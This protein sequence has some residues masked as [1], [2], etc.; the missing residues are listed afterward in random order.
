M[1][2]LWKKSD[3]CYSNGDDLQQIHRVSDVISKICAEKVQEQLESGEHQEIPS[4]MKSNDSNGNETKI[5]A[6]NVNKVNHED[7]LRED[8]GDAAVRF[9][10]EGY[11]EEMGGG[12]QAMHDVIAKKSTEFTHG[13]RSLS[14]SP[15]CEADEEEISGKRGLVKKVVKNLE[16]DDKIPLPLNAQHQILDNKSPS[17]KEKQVASTINVFVNN[18]HTV[19]TN[20]PEKLGLPE[21]LECSKEEG[22]ALH[23]IDKLGK[24][25]NA[26]DILIFTTR[27]ESMT[28]TAQSTKGKKNISQA[29]SIPFDTKKSMRFSTSFLYNPKY[30]K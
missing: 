8:R 3:E 30:P 12:S 29:G 20:V 28:A 24:S 22:R 13:S 15:I 9:G 16:R 25:S 27:K 26:K 2:D 14:C 18:D 1:M 21:I 11:S 17:R 7:F 5:P 10:D 6:F 4:I 19:N 23:A